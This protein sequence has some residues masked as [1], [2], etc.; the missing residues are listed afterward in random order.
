M[1]SYARHPGMPID[2][3]GWWKGGVSR[4]GHEHAQAVG[5]V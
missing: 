5:E 3:E 4:F 1:D 2:L